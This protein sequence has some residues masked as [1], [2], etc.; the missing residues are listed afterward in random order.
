MRVWIHGLACS[1]PVDWL[2]L[3]SQMATGLVTGLL[4]IITHSQQIK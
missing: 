1:L 3:L 4:V 2:L